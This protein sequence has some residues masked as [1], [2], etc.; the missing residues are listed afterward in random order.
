MAYDYDTQILAGLWTGAEDTEEPYV[1]FITDN[2]TL[3]DDA[4]ENRILSTL[5]ALRSHMELLKSRGEARLFH[6]CVSAMLESFGSGG[7]VYGSTSDNENAVVEGNI[8]N[9]VFLAGDDIDVA[10]LDGV[11]TGA[12]VAG[13]SPVAVG[14]G[15]SLDDF[16]SAFNAAGPAEYVASRTQD[17]RLRI[18]QS[19]TGGATAAAGLVL[20]DGPV[21]A[22]AGIRLADNPTQSGATGGIFLAKV[23]AVANAARDRALAVF[24]GQTRDTD[25]S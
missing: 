12:G 2:P 4:A 20:L 11:S 24:A 25:F 22:K 6:F 7:F 10:V 15:G 1:T 14:G 17:N 5:E 18:T 21:V 3:T 19:P 13:L 8:Q 9:P 16:I 23:T